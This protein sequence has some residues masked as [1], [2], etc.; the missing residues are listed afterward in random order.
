VIRSSLFALI[1]LVAGPA[2]AQQ[3]WHGPYVPERQSTQPPQPPQE[4]APQKQAPRQPDRFVRDTPHVW[5]AQM[6]GYKF[7]NPQYATALNTR[8][9]IPSS[10]HMAEE[11]WVRSARAEIARARKAPAHVRVLTIPRAKLAPSLDGRIYTEEWAGALRLPMEPA[12]GGAVLM[13]AH[14]GQVYVAAH[15]FGDKTAA[16]YDQFRFWF[17]IG[18]SPYLRNERVHLG[19]R[20][21]PMVLRDVG[22]PPEREA[23][24]EDPPAGK[25]T[26]KTDWN[27]FERTRG[28]SGVE[29]YRQYELSVDMAEAGFFA[30]TP[31]PAY[32]EIEGDPVLDA[33]GRFKARTTVGA[34]GSAAAPVWL[35]IAP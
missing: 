29:G 15:A 23:I 33:A 1:F 10:S 31:F 20:G 17:H 34:A 21:K 3:A 16:G 32:F 35:Q 8:G 13:L 11:Q 22:L 2:P 26:H 5:L 4:P 19:G 25:L 9:R 30:G 14:G 6:I 18:L 27:I 28:A 12:S 24:L 7:Y